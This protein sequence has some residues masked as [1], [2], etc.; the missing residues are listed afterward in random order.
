MFSGRSSRCSHRLLEIYPELTLA[1][2]LHEPLVVV[3]L[4]RTGKIWKKSCSIRTALAT[5]SPKFS[6]FFFF[7]EK[8]EKKEKQ[9]FQSMEI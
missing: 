1:H 4:T 5:F 3:V 6:S 7:Q 9:D 2:M 8:Q